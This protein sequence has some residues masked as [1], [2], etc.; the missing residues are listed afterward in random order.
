[1]KISIITATFNSG[2]T[3]RDTIQTVLTQTYQEIEYII[4]DGNSRDNTLEIVREFEPYFDGR[5]KWISEPD[6][7]IYDAMNKGIRMATGDIIGIL[8]SDD[9][10]NDE[11]VLAD[12]V[13]A[14][15]CKKTDCVYGNLVFVDS[16]KPD[17]IVRRWIGSQ[18][19]PGAFLKGW[20]P[21]HPTFYARRT[22]FEQYGDFDLSF[23]ISAD[24]ELMLR[25]IEKNG[26]SN[27]YINRCFV[28]MRQGGAS[29]GSIKNIIKGN[30]NILRA[31]RKNGYHISCLY[32]AK[33]LLPKL[34]NVITTQIR[35]E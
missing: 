24:F 13:N 33:R 2:A 17:K 35:L 26:C 7:G 22:C 18:H 29:T 19:T 34:I 8:N 5:M 10:Y 6:N 23:E 11:N 15:G 28:K 12:I 31:F 14:F 16:A 27:Y 25:F 4:I 3:L 1:M 21:A 32:P 20:H 9:F 30:K